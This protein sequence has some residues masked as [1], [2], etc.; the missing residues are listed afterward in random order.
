MHTLRSNAGFI[1]ALEIMEAA[2]T[3]ERAIEQG[4]PGEPG[5]GGISA[6]LDLLEARI[7]AIV[8]AARALA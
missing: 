4:E 7:T 3:L 8:D 5:D 1:C 2:G 6:G